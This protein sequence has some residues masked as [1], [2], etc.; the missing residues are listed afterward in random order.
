LCSSMVI[1][2]LQ[3]LSSSAEL[4]RPS[5]TYLIQFHCSQRWSAGL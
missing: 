2:D 1:V 3:V 4:S 5:G